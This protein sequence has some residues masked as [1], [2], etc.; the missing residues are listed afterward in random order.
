MNPFR[1]SCSKCPDLALLHM[2][3][4]RRKTGLAI[5]TQKISL[6]ARA[7][8]YSQTVNFANRLSEIRM[9]Q[10]RGAKPPV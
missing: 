7:E 5:H 1:V 6:A 2:L 9:V 3:R 10:P 8:E 4:E